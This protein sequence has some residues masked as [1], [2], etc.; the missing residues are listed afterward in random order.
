M[1]QLINLKKST[2]SLTLDELE[3]SKKMAQSLLQTG[4]YQKLGAAGIFAIIQMAKSIGADVMQCLNGGMYP[5]D[6]KIEMDGKLMMALI[7]QAGHSVT[8]D[9]RS[10][11]TLCILHGKRADT[12]DTWTE[13]FGI[14][15]A[16]A[17]GL[18]SRGSYQK[19]GR[20]MF[21]WRALSRLARFLFPDV[22][23]GCYVSGEISDA[24]RLDEPV[25]LEK[26][27]KI[28]QT[29]NFKI[30]SV[31]PSPKKLIEKNLVESS[32]VTTEMI[33]ELEELFDSD[34]EYRQKVLEFL[35]KNYHTDSLDEMPL[36]VYEKV[37]ARAA[38]RRDAKRQAE[39]HSF[40]CFGETSQ[41]AMGG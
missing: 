6:G 25:D 9:K 28:A 36:S 22:I 11:P 34:E 13:S 8:K 33:K 14:E 37:Y 19:Y 24:P 21:Q 12:G 20:D 7:R 40:S 23:K 38:E 2:Y 35:D 10:T 1:N 39:D 3:D 16:K 41:L 15:D 18:L 17:A 4:H 26:E 29:V 30:E 5:I 32:Q 31:T 27:E